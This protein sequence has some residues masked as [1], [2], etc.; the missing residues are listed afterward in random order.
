MGK[1]WSNLAKYGTPNGADVDMVWPKYNETEDMHL[2][3]KDPPVPRS[4][5]AAK[6]CNFW[7][8]LP[9]MGD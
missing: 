6:H 7:D 5:L 2:V 9:G 3:L 8:T 4:G 1:Y